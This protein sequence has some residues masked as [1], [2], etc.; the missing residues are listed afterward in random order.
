MVEQQLTTIQREYDLEKQQYS[1][2]SGKQRA[3]ALAAN[4]ERGR[5]GERFEVIDAAS[6]PDTP[7]K[8]IPIRV[9]LG[10]ILAGLLLGAGLTLG[11]EYF[12]SSV[13]DERELRDEF[14]LPILGSITHFPA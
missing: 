12:D 5:G 13:H 7:I 3:A 8:P 1:E 6:L 9:M 2:L 11:R 14:S 10:A 4:V